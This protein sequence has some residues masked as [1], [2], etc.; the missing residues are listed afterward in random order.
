MRTETN[1]PSPA[2]TNGK[3]GAGANDRLRPGAV[4]SSAGPAA[5]E[6]PRA[7]DSAAW[8]PT[9][10]G[11]SP[12]WLHDFTPNELTELA[13]LSGTALRGEPPSASQRS[14][15]A[16]QMARTGRE[17]QS[18]LGFR[19]L[20]GLPV[21]ELT[22]QEA[23]ATF[24]ALS[25]RLG[26][27]MEQSR[28]VTLAHVRADEDNNPHGLGFRAAGA[29]PFHA[30]L[31]D[32]IGFLCLRP[33]RCGGARRFASAAT[34]YNILAAD[35]PEHLRVLTRPL[36]VA[37]QEPHPDHGHR[38]TRLPF[39][40]VRDGVFNACA[41]PVHIKRARRLAGV[42]ELTGAQNRA[43]EVFNEVADQVAVSLELRPGDVEYFNN[44]V[45][46]HSR[47]P[48]AGDGSERHLL[49][50]WL[51]MTDFRPLHPE[52][53]IRLRREGKGRVPAA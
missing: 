12:G 6:F 4:A 47:T 50:V 15:L 49:R 10:L 24:M 5:E 52:H 28:G 16:W 19:I 34:V 25:R 7:S 33:A 36:H 39:V 22:E 14:F 17:L 21:E 40:S 44:H 8:T 23:A 18:G 13:E 51:S 29:L 3:T 2:D 37:L 46:L 53:P 43:L 45:V 27:P 20:R 26:E 41:W 42:P 9:D 38:W 1:D 30:D 48:F 11:R 31:E 35:Y 32:V